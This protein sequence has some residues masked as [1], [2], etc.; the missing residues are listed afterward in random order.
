MIS[1]EN[2]QEINSILN[3]KNVNSITAAIKNLTHN[4]TVSF[5]Y[6]NN[7]T[8]DSLDKYDNFQNSVYRAVQD[9]LIVASL[10][11][12]NPSLMS[13]RRL[14]IINNFDLSNDPLSTNTLL[15]ILNYIIKEF[16]NDNILA[17][18]DYFGI[19]N[20]KIS[21]L[22]QLNKIFA[23][24]FFYKQIKPINSKYKIA[25]E[26]A[27]VI[28]KEAFNINFLLNNNE[29]EPDLQLGFANLKTLLYRNVDGYPNVNF[30]LA[31]GDLKNKLSPEL[32]QTFS[33]L[34]DKELLERTSTTSEFAIELFLHEL[35]HF[36]GAKHADLSPYTTEEEYSCT[37]MDSSSDLRYSN[38]NFFINLGPNDI[39]ALEKVYSINTTFYL[40]DNTYNFNGNSNN[41]AITVQTILDRDGYN[42][43]DTTESKTNTVINLFYGCMEPSVVGKQKFFIDY[44]SHINEIR[45][46]SGN[47]IINDFI[48]QDL[49][50]NMGQ[51]KNTYEL[52]LNFNNLSKTKTFKSITTKD[53]IILKGVDCNFIRS[54]SNL[55][56]NKLTLASTN[57]GAIII[58]NAD[59]YT[60]SQIIIGKNHCDFHYDE[61]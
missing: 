48:D 50:I 14:K 9:E 57:G 18:L 52:E 1:K 22:K 10:D 32:P 31:L 27:I 5:T 33:I 55:E 37:V 43:I 41:K 12:E 13:K 6:T 26:Q 54:H 3:D 19:K 61:L 4:G 44:D 56:N 35:M 42:V 23:Q 47:D 39:K 29:N 2:K 8:F 17:Y 28:L 25:F 51:G 20:N 40:G 53:S 58:E 36:L 59:Q 21:S 60:I 24:K 11:Q 34:I 46:G 49:I 45:T 15:D 7:P 38:H 30:E 16:N